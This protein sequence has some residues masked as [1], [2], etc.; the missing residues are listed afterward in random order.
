MIDHE[1][2]IGELGSDEIKRIDDFR[3]EKDTSVLVVMFTD[4][5]GSTEIAELRGESYANEMRKLHNK[6]LLEIIERNRQGLYIKNI[7]DSI[8]A[9][10]SE[11]SVAVERALEIQRSLSNYNKENPK[12]EPMVVR[13]GMHMGQV[14]VEDTTSV[15]VFGR[16]VNRAARVQSLADGGHTYL[17]YSIYDSAKGWI[18]DKNLIF[19]KHGDYSVK[20]IP[21][22]VQIYEVYE[23]GIN[24]P[25]PPSIPAIKEGKPKKL[26]LTLPVLAVLL[27][28]FVIFEVFFVDRS[29]IETEQAPVVSDV[30]ESP[31]T[32][33][34]LP[35]IDISPEKDQEY[36]VDG[37]SEE[38]LN[39]I[40]K[41]AGLRV[42]SRTSCF[43][44]KGTNK[45]AQEIGNELGVEHILEGSVRKD[46]DALRITAQLIRAEDDYHL[47]SETYD[48]ELKD[49]FAVQEGIA[50]AVADKLKLTLGVRKSHKQLGGTDN[51][52]AYEL[53]L[54]AKGQQLNLDNI[55]ALESIDRA[56]ALDPG[57]A[58]A[59]VLKGLI[60]SL[61]ASGS[62]ADRVSLEI[63]AGLNAAL[64]AIELE[65]SLPQAYNILG[66]AYTKSG[67]FIEAELAYRKAM[68]LS[69]ESIYEGNCVMHYTSLGYLR[70][71]DGILE[72]MRRNDPL[73]PLIRAAYILNLGYLGDMERAEEEYERGKAI[74]GDQWI[75]GDFNIT[76]LRLGAKDV[77]SRDDIP[78]IPR[79][80]P[81]WSRI[82]ELI[83]SPEEGLAEIRRSSS[84][85]NISS[86]ALQIMACLA[87]SGGDPEL[88]LDLME[89][90]VTLTSQGLYFI[91]APLMREVRQLPRFKEFV[92]EIGLVDYWDEFGWP[93]LCR[94]LDNDDFECD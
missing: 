72:E 87:G 57:F 43:T 45:K 25:K 93:D 9:V 94:P 32:I 58:L 30:E 6:I 77:V 39:C 33:A 7:G 69:P 4:L 67:E 73:Q 63:D 80:D 65:P 82:R 90:S 19:K 79:F 18:K 38:L 46:G 37:L 12:E 89:R 1:K 26:W 78:A 70:K 13:I 64:R 88:A 16:H 28:G 20:G 3:R 91:W 31:K 21:D 5:V 74:F 8:M 44:F 62:S 76:W 86:G 22:P 60:H 2:I 15:D 85:D 10:F 35:F 51:L 83:E 53:F 92:R 34:V 48:R 56:I 59:W 52:D 75:W 68:E 54:V 66:A 49:I 71:C 36:F 41:I 81:M 14:A 24:R 40:S 17:T 50:T 23:Y 29:P 27:L 42:T 55:Q 61:L 84:N 11:P 47:W